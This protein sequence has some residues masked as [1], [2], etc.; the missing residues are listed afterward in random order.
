MTPEHWKKFVNL[1]S[2]IGREFTVPEEMDLSEVGADFE[3]LSEDQS[4]DE[5]KNYW[6]G[7]GV[8]LDGFI[9][10]AG[11]S[12]GSGDPYFININDGENGPLYR[13]YHDQVNDSGYDRNIAVDVILENY[14]SLLDYACYY[15]VWSQDRNGNNTELF[16]GLLLEVAKKQVAELKL[17]KDRKKYWHDQ[18][19]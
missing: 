18:S 5:A 6:P 7:I 2:L 16:N 4:I 19:D 3:V 11:C 8:F 10:V 14:Q 13:V 12:I 17:K 15:S 9:P 1:N